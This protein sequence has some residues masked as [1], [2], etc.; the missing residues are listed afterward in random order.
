LDEVSDKI[1]HVL[2]DSV[3]T[4]LHSITLKVNRSY[5]YVALTGLES[6]AVDLDAHWNLFEKLCREYNEKAN[7][8]QRVIDEVTKSENAVSELDFRMLRQVSEIMTIQGADH[9]K[10]L[11]EMHCF[12]AQDAALLTQNQQPVGLAE[13][14][15]DPKAAASHVIPILKQIEELS[16]KFKTLKFNDDRLVV[17]DLPCNDQTRLRKIDLEIQWSNHMKDAF[18]NVKEVF[19]GAKNTLTKLEQSWLEFWKTYLLCQTAVTTNDEKFTLLRTHQQEWLDNLQGSS[20]APHVKINW[21]EETVVLFNDVVKLHNG[22][23]E[24]CGPFESAEKMIKNVEDLQQQSNENGVLFGAR[25]QDQNQLMIETQIKVVEVLNR[26]QLV[27]SVGLEP[28]MNYT[29]CEKF[30]L[31][32]PKKVRLY[33]NTSYK[34]HMVVNPN[35]MGKMQETWILRS[36]DVYLNE[37]FTVCVDVQRL[38]VKLDTEVIDFGYVIPGSSQERVI[39][40]KSV[41]DL[42]LLVKSQLQLGQKIQRSNLRLS[43]DCFKLLPRST[44]DLKVS[45]KASQ[46]PEK[47]SSFTSNH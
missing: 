19:Q 36:D 3:S 43:Q 16:N 20:L 14:I 35:V 28:Q 45:L 8:F 10:A 29:G 2:D 46:K 40:M 42:P 41:T 47:S 25:M 33:G 31:M 9:S 39:Q 11:K 1:V 44:Q 5:L 15:S 17:I 23:I 12:L 4:G 26:T 21:Q 7:D 24:W 6:Y 18:L 22:R 32:A 38:G 27:M 13:D 37:I 34:F 30:E